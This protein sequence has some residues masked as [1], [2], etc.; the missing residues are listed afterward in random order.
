MTGNFGDF[1]ILL[2]LILLYLFREIEIYIM[3]IFGLRS[4]FF[5]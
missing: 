1:E 4:F 5:L 3:R 2:F